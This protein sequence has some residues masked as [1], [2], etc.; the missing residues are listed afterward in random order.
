LP[1]S[2]T[3]SSVHDHLARAQAHFLEDQKDGGTSIELALSQLCGPDVIITPISPNDEPPRPLFQRYW[4][5]IN[6]GDYRRSPKPYRDYADEE[7]RSLVSD[8]Y[9]PEIAVLN[10]EF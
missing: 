7:T 9:A 8:W 3:S 2:A 4:F 5:E 10:Y 1:S 6:A